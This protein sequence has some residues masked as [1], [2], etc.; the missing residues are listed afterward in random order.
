MFQFFRIFCQ[1]FALHDVASDNAISF[2]FKTDRHTDFSV[3]LLCKLD[4]RKRKTS[5]FCSNQPIS[6]SGEKLSK[7]KKIF[8]P[9]LF[10][11]FPESTHFWDENYLQHYLKTLNTN[12]LFLTSF[13]RQSKAS[14][15]VQINHFDRC[16][17]LI[18][19]LTL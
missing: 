18:F 7:I 4:R 10:S 8:T 16:L 11:L 3:Q 15:Q 12:T 14:F 19:S 9:F 5:L 13:L 6:F 17:V 2:S 1:Y